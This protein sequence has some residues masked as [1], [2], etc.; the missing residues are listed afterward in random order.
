MIKKLQVFVS[1]TYLDLINERQKAV[2]GILRS[3]HIPAG[4]ELFIPSDKTQ[5]EIIRGW[6]KDS[7]LLM[8]ILG[9]RY[10]NIEPNS[11]KSYT[12]LEYEYAVANK[13]PVFA[14]ILNDQFLANK[15]SQNVN[16]K[17]YEHE[18]ENPNIEKYSSFKKEVMSN[19]VSM[20]ED[21]NQISTEVSLAL[22]EFI[23]KD[24]TEYHFR[25]WIKGENKPDFLTLS[26]EYNVQS[27]IDDKKRQGL[28]ELTINTYKLELRIFKNYFKD[29]NVTE[30]DTI[31]IKEFLRYREDNYSI[32]SRR[33]L[34][35][36]RGQLNNFF[37]WL[38]DEGIVN[39]NPVKKIKPFRFQKK[40]NEA[41]NNNEVSELRNACITLRERAIL[42]TLLSTGCHLAEI[43]EIG[44]NNIDWF[45]KTITIHSN[46]KERVVFLSKTLE[47]H[48]KNYLDVRK[49]NLNILFVTDRKP[50]RQ[51]SNRGI[52]REIKLIAGR[53]SINK[54]ISP[55]TFRDTFAKIMLDKGYQSSIV[56]LFLGYHSKAIR[57]E[58][59]F[60]ISNDNIWE[61]ISSRP[62][63]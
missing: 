10:G 23:S 12:H 60:N 8:L 9:G 3:K 13:I 52:Q 38:A 32:K 33:S 19:L 55:R 15:K 61:V 26:V 45:N 50:Y 51:L 41:L 48:L 6:I 54:S 11:G 7:D 30:I 34:E 14:I 29:I 22:Q 46:E 20:V 43:K 18:N 42:E 25:G 40:G 5:W 21:I 24:R 4:M 37:N 47:K 57:S 62:D 2:E 53:T 44:L 49:D 16:L 1:S 36:T 27:F 63:I 31:K 35:S 28:S 39:N 59:Y 58:S 56:D 17:I